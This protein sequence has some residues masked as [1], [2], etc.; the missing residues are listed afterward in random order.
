MRRHDLILHIELFRHTIHHVIHAFAEVFLIF[1]KYM[2]DDIL[3]FATR[4]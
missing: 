3:H 4:R 1:R 2:M